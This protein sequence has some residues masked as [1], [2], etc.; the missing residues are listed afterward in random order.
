M[1][2]GKKRPRRRDWRPERDYLLSETPRWEGWG[3]TSYVQ[4]LTVFQQWGTPLP[5][6][7]TERENRSFGVYWA[8]QEE[9]LIYWFLFFFIRK[10]YDLLKIRE[11][12]VTS[13]VWRLWR[14]LEIER[15]ESSSVNTGL[16][17]RLKLEIMK[18]WRYQSAPLF[19]IHLYLSGV[20]VH[21]QPS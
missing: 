4:T 7:R 3:P 14:K 10:L 19:C 6:I 13:R 5:H 16:P 18:L 8:E 1:P 9:V 11:D 12:S 20:F 15:R 17:D 21:W 2:K